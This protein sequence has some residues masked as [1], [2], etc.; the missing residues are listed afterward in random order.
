MSRVDCGKPLDMYSAAPPMMSWVLSVTR[1]EEMLAL[2]TMRP[3]TKPMTADATRPTAMAPSSGRPLSLTRM[4][5]SR[6]TNPK[7]APTDR[8]NCPAVSSMVMPSAMRPT[9]GKNA[10][11]PLRFPDDTN[12]GFHVQNT[13][14]TTTSIAAGRASGTAA[15]LRTKRQGEA[16]AGAGGWPVAGSVACSVVLLT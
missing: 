6:G 16:G 2:V 8:S 13:A 14:T 1:N 11:M 12:A 10:R 9:S 3:L 15:R 7:T 4:N 5:T